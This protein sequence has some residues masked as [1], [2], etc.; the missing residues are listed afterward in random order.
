MAQL[1]A[2][3][4]GHLGS[5]P[6]LPELVQ[7]AIR[8]LQF[9]ATL[10]VEP[11]LIHYELGWPNQLGWRGKI[12]PLDAEFTGGFIL[13]VSD[14]EFVIGNSF[15]A[16]AS[17]EIGASI[18]LGFVGAEVKALA[19]VGFGARYI[20]V[21]PVKSP[22][23]FAFYGAIGLE[24]RLDLSFSFWI[25]LTINLGFK[26]IKIRKDFRLSAAIDFTAGLEI[27]IRKS[28]AGV[29]G[30]GTL[31]LSAMG[32]RLELSVNLSLG[33]EHVQWALERTQQYLQM[34]LE[35][36]EVEAV[37]GLAQGPSQAPKAAFA[38]AAAL[39]AA[40]ET[41]LQCPGLHPLRRAETGPGQGLLPVAA[42]RR[43]R[44]FSA[45][46][47]AYRTPHRPGKRY[48]FRTISS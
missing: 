11:G 35:A 29:R 19:R 13:R 41:A 2:N 21:L 39:F 46:A 23:D 20:G 37:P 3:P 9:S 36:T 44:G 15:M 17:L 25:G 24:A 34:G 30:Q 4:D 32:H 31:A 48:R 10:L 8:G 27:G 6:E 47:T 14:Q 1:S 28:G 33:E 43:S 22:L 5:N 16:R 18:D 7:K 12:G 26:K 38:L 42:A 45:T 40:A